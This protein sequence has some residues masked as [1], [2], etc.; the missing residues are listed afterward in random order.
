MASE[1]CCG[2]KTLNVS[3]DDVEY[4]SH[5]LVGVRFG[6]TVAD[7][8]LDLFLTDSLCSSDDDSSHGGDYSG[9][10]RCVIDCLHPPAV[11]SYG[12]QYCQSTQ[13]AVLILIVS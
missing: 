13:H 2:H 3:L 10:Y 11:L 4:A 1:C 12:A 5:A 6:N 7:V 8:Q 9:Q